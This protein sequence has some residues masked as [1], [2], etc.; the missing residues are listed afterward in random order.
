MWPLMSLVLLSLSCY[1]FI[2]LQLARCRALE[3]EEKLDEAEEAFDETLTKNCD[4]ARAE[5]QKMHRALSN[6]H[7]ETDRAV[8]G[9]IETQNL[10]DAAVPRLAKL[11]A[12][13]EV[14]APEILPTP[15][16]DN[17]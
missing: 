8:K 1:L 10:L 15:L 5:L 7:E 11:R 4:W 6:A 16:E 17:Q 13:E 3:A 2:L 12:I 9:H 14:L